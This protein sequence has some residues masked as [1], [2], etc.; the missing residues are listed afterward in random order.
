M[1]DMRYHDLPDLTETVRNKP[2]LSETD[3]DCDNKKIIACYQKLY[4]ESLVLLEPIRIILP[5]N[6][7]IMEGQGESSM[8]EFFTTY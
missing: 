3:T 6:Q 7:A 2:I 1:I 5:Q 4:H 8:V